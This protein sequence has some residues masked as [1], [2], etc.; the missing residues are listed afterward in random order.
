VNRLASS[1][2]LLL[3][4]CSAALAQTAPTLGRVKVQQAVVRCAPGDQSPETGKLEFGSYVTVVAKEGNDWLCIQPPPGSISWV[5]WALVE[6]QKRNPNDQLAPPFNA[7]ISIEKGASALIRA[8]KIGDDKPLSAQRTKLPNGT[9]VQVIG[10]KKKLLL[11]GDSTET[12]WY[13]IAAPADDFRFIRRDAVEWSGT[14]VSTGFVVKDGNSTEK[15]LPGKVIEKTGGTGDF[16]V[17]IGDRPRP[18]G[19]K[20]DPNEHP[21][22]REAEKARGNGESVRAEKLYQEIADE[23]SPKGPYQ[24]IDLANLCYDRIFLLRQGNNGGSKTETLRTPKL[25]DTPRVEEK[26]TSSGEGYLRATRYKIAGA[27]VYALVDTK[28]IVRHY[29]VSGG[30]DLDKYLGKWVTLSGEETKP[31]ELRGDPLLTAKVVK[32]GQ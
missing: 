14:P 10:N 29:T 3:G 32:T 7:V 6:P 15:P 2:C 17:S 13:P 22:F 27:A 26:Y 5:N 16:T 1:L 28:G 19:S 24:D 12:N 18:S 23:V 8:G 31:E 9:I 20:W 30:V 11:D 25:T 21:K 4:L